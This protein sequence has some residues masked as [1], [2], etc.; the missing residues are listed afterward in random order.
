MAR[1]D[2]LHDVTGRCAC[3]QVA[4]TCRIE[5]ETCC[6][7][8]DLCKRSSGSAFQ[9]WVDGDRASLKVTGR[10]DSWHSSD[11]ATRHFCPACGSTLFLFEQGEPDVVEVSAGTIDAPDGILGAR[12]AYAHRRPGWSGQA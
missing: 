7:S 8:C 5:T 1:P 4:F 11:H 6:C 12:H 9:S 10:V 3:G 2:E